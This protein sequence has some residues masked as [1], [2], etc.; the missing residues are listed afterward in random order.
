[1]IQTPLNDK[2]IITLSEKI[3]SSDKKDTLNLYIKEVAERCAGLCKKGE[4][5][6]VMHEYKLLIDTLRKEFN[7]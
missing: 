6:R 7:L 4:N 1:M 3:E 5:T 2:L